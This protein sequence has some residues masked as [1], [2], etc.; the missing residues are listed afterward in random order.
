MRRRLVLSYSLL[1]LLVLCALETPLAVTLANRET[2][3]VRAD[4]LADA[5]R[6]ASLS[7]T[8]LRGG[9]VSGIADELRRYQEL[10][11]ISAAVFDREQRRIVGAGDTHSD[12]DRTGSALWGALAGRQTT[13]PE[14]AWPW[15]DA[16]L[17][18]A[19]PV[20]DGG[21]VI[22]AVV[23]ISPTERVRRTVTL[24]WTMLAGVG[25]LALSAG[26]M[27]AFRLAGW[28]LRPITVLDVVTHDIAA[29]DGTARVPTGQGPPELR[30]LATSFNEMADALADALDR[31]RAFVAHA[32]HQLRNPL[33]ALRLRVEELGPSLTDECGRE[34]HR[35]ALEETD[36]LA[37]VLD[38]LLTLAR[39]ERAQRNLVVVDAA[40]VAASRVAAWQPLANHR[41]ITLV[42]AEVEAP[43]HVHAVP[44]GL[45]QVLDALIDNSVK[46]GRPDGRVEV[47]VRRG[48]GGVLIRVRDDG[49]GMTEAQLKS[50][51]ERFWRAPDTQN[52]DGA[53]LGLT[54]VAGLVDASGGRLSMRPAEPTGLVAEVWL[55]AA[56]PAAEPPPAGPA[57]SATAG[58]DG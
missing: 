27:I 57:A 1:M 24:W 3:R 11:G 35:L 17:L 39:T 44:T 25:L 19:V 30:R 21:E 41:R 4:R 36:R 38:G 46:F 2:E 42:L 10:Y 12:P 29:G 26:V 32:S 14:V 16:P 6:F 7:G 47:S 49:P 5:N 23:T 20:T 56:G 37:Q 18:V 8:A 22:G 53:G 9:A 33:T 48:D 15:R 13:L 51:T 34:E 45:D 43:A 28:V 54:I 55:R 58:G 50:S 52:I 31:Q 40:A